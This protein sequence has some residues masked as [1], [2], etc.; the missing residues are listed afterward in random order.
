MTNAERQKAY[1]NRNGSGDRQGR[2]TVNGHTMTDAERRRNYKTRR[3]EAGLTVNDGPNYQGTDKVGREFIGLDGE[4]DPVIVPYDQSTVYQKVM[5]NER[6]WQNYLLAGEQKI[7]WK[8]F[9]SAILDGVGGIRL[10]PGKYASDWQNVIPSRFRRKNG[11]YPDEAAEHLKR[12]YPQFGVTDPISLWERLSEYQAWRGEAQPHRP[13]KLSRDFG[14]PVNNPDKYV[15]LAASDGTELFDRLKGLTTIQCF[16]YLLDLSAR[17]KGWSDWKKRAPAA[18]FLWFFCKY[19]VDMILGDLPVEVLERL[20]RER[21]ARWY[22]EEGS[23]RYYCISWTP[24]KRFSVS[25]KAG[26]PALY[27]QKKGEWENRDKVLGMFTSYDIAGFTQGGFVKACQGWGLLPNDNPDGSNDDPT[28]SFLREMKAKRGS[29]TEV[30][31]DTLKRYNRL[32]VDYIAQMGELIWKSH[33]DLGLNL[34]SMHGA[35]ATAG[36]LLRKYG[37]IEHISNE[38]PASIREHV[39]GG[40]FGGQIQLHRL[41]RAKEVYSYDLNSA[42]PSAANLLPSLKESQWYPVQAFDPDLWAIWRVRWDCTPLE[43]QG[44]HRIF[45]FPFRTSGGR[46]KWQAKGEGWYWTPEVKIALKY[47]PGMIHI[48]EGEALYLPFQDVR[49]FAFLEGL[50]DLRRRLKEGEVYDIREKVVKVGTASVYGKLAEGAHVYAY[51][52]GKPIVSIPRHQ[53]YTYAGLITSITRARLLEAAMISPRDIIGFATDCIFSRVDLGLPCSKELGGWDGKKGYNGL[54]IQPG[55]YTVHQPYKDPPGMTRHNRGFL[56][57]EFDWD[58]VEREFDLINGKT[59]F[60]FKSRRFIGMGAGLAWG[61]E[62]WRTWQE[63]DKKL[64]AISFNQYPYFGVYDDT[65]SEVERHEVSTIVGCW[66][67]EEGVSAPYRPKHEFDPDGLDY[68]ETEQLSLQ[69]EN[70]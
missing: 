8:E 52:D 12:D 20:H 67:S 68:L 40:Y 14:K 58:R 56:N 9:C 3:R 1:R 51:V 2:P 24:G 27:N 43:E 61:L 33:A 48:I 46:I 17:H 6:D 4:S 36:L 22:F 5:E 53:C 55:V 63:S 38:M 64:D 47:Y 26:R 23:H 65:D 11:L 19:D 34:S 62:K 49:P 28:V 44:E 18:R 15:L 7:V 60:T 31:D 54:F 30:D 66:N 37:V 21:T 25:L 35:G 42:Y 69:P 10:P 70:E 59:S 13:E 41:G 16:D 39:R 29:F 45:P 57:S 32:E 50:Y